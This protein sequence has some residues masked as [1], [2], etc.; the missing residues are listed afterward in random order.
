MGK[1]KEW[2]GIS[3]KNKV[4]FGSL[5]VIPSALVVGSSV[6]IYKDLNPKH[7]HTVDYKYECNYDGTHNKV[8]YCD[9]K[10]G[11]KCEGFKS[12]TVNE[13]CEL[14]KNEVCKYCDYH[15]Y[16]TVTFVSSIDKS[17]IDKMK[18][19]NGSSLDPEKDF[20]EPP[21]VEG[22]NFL[23]FEGEWDDLKKD[24]KITL[25]YTKK[26]T[27]ENKE[28]DENNNNNSNNKNNSNNTSSNNGNNQNPSNND[29][30]PQQPQPTDPNNNPVDNN[31]SNNNP[32]N[33]INTSPTNEDLDNSALENVYRV[34]EYTETSPVADKFYTEHGFGGYEVKNGNI[35]YLIGADGAILEIGSIFNL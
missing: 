28:S 33:N 32:S 6:F 4:I 31:P 15:K 24:T 10:D 27:E 9:E 26:E 25:V 20:P 30:A 3:I 12:D 13:K 22:Y 29:P 8:S 17:E 23:V 35:L 21:E 19:K 11:L 7:E 1:M 18:V 14:D 34:I 5:C 16:M 2:L